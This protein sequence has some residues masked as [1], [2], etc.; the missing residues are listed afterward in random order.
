MFTEIFNDTIPSYHLD[1]LQERYNAALLK[2]TLLTLKENKG[3][4]K[5]QN[6]H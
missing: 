1:N 6:I 4:M 5:T 3:V 2:I